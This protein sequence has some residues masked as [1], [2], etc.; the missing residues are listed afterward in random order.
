MPNCR[1][2]DLEKR[3]FYESRGKPELFRDL[4]V[5]FN[6]VRE[7]TLFGPHIT[8][9]EACMAV[10]KLFVSFAVN[11]CKRHHFTSVHFSTIVL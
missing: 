4:P 2:S 5:I 7:N 3:P 9:I 8:L 6:Q 11:R 10:R 1:G